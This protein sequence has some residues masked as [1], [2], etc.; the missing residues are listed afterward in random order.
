MSDTAISALATA[1]APAD[2]D[3]LVLVQSGVTKKIPYSTLIRPS[4]YPAFLAHNSVTDNNVTGNYTVVTVNFDTEIFDQGNNFSGDTFTAPV[5]GRYRFSTAINYTG[6]VNGTEFYAYL[7]TSNRNYQL[8]YKFTAAISG[9]YVCNGSVLV[10]MDAGDTA[11]VKARVGGVG[12][13]TVDVYG[14]TSSQLYTF[15][16]GE[17]VC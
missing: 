5:T 16:S 12:A 7:F 9:N 2:A 4:A 15:F 8:D 17:L 14:D 11:V 1:T 13:D 3:Y 10:D 6:I